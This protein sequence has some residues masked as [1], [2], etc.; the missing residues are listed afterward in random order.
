MEI[1]YILLYLLLLGAGFLL[2][3]K[4]SDYF[5]DGASGIAVRFQIPQ[6]IIGLTIVAMGT[7]LPEAAV[8]ITAAFEGNADITIGNIVGSNILNIFIILGLASVI[9][10]IAVKASTIKYEIPY[11]IL[12]SILL[13][14]LG[15]DGIIGFVDGIIFWAAF[16]L[17]LVYLFLG[18]RKN[19]EE[20]ETKQDTKLWKQIV[21]VIGGMAAIILGSKLAVYGATEIA[22]LWG[23]SERFIGLTIVAL[24]TSLPELFTSVIAARKGNA[25]IAIGNIVGSNIFNILFVIGTT[26]F[27]TQ[28][29]YEPK[30]MIDG[31]ITIGSA[32][33]LLLCTLRKKKLTRVHGII[34]LV[35]YAAYFAYLCLY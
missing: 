29:P 6:I 26:A 35:M 9:V 27:I 3:V 34:M 2:L 13:V 10:P 31:Y 33:V 4:G 15:L 30:F 22:R 32:V 14:L 11:M 23:V 8:S 1:L 21:F 5:V 20:Q 19:K 17:Y 28:V 18:A 24:G 16:V 25:D 7:S 12:C